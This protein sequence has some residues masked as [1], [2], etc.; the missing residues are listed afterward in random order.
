MSICSV[1]S[2]NKKVVAS[3]LCSTHYQRLRRH[4]DP[5]KKFVFRGESVWYRF[6]SSVKISNGCWE[7]IGSKSVDG[8]GRIYVEGKTIKAHRLSFELNIGNIPKDRFVCHKCDN[9]ICVRPGHLFI[10]TQAENMSDKINKHRDNMK[11]LLSGEN[12]WMRKMPQ[13]IAKGESCGSAILTEQEVINLRRIY[14]NG[15][16]KQRELAR[17]HNIN[18]KN[19]N[20]ILNRKTWKHLPIIK[21]GVIGQR[22]A[23]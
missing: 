6:W 17:R 7:W 2:C 14:A 3:D 22:E 23:A 18:S 9:P 13:R 19:L 15:G 5:F 21:N 20:L 16:I 8:Y 1:D 11:L 10:G 12:H 4:G